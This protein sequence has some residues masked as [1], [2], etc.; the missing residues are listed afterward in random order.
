MVSKYSNEIINH[1]EGYSGI[2]NIPSEI[3]SIDYTSIIYCL[4]TPVPNSGIGSFSSQ[5]CRTHR[6][7][8]TM[9]MEIMIWPQ[10]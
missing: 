6:P 2:P 1:K 5:P 8:P 3:S 4:Y 7:T 10:S 9:L